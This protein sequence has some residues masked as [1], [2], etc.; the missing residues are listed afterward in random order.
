MP[1]FKEIQALLAKKTPFV[2][3]VKPNENKWNLLIQNNDEV[4]PFSGQS[5]FVFAPFDAG[6]KVVIPIMKL[7]YQQEFWKKSKQIN[8]SI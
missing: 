6:L 1:I 2:C 5:G 4:I 8:Q 7:I 3:Y